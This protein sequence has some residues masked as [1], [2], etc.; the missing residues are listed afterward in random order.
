[1]RN[2]ARPVIHRIQELRP[3]LSARGAA[4]AGPRRPAGPR[5]RWS[6]AC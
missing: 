2:R 1:M 3:V 4:A 5:A 6:R